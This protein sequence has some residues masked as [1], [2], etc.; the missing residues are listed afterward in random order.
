MFNETINATSNVLTGL[1]VNGSIPLSVTVNTATNW[2]QFWL[3]AG[4]A[5]IT[6]FGLI[7]LIYLPNLV[8]S[9]SIG[10]LSKIFKMTQRNVVLIKHT[11][12]GLFG[13]SMIDQQCLRDLSEVMN[14][15]EGADFDLILHSPGGDIFSSLTLSRLIKQYPGHIR[16]IIP[17]YS[18]SG[19]SLLALSCKELLMT[20]NACIGP[21]DPQLGSLFKFG[22]AKAW[23]EIVKFKGRKAEDQSISFAMMGK[24]YTK[25]ISAHLGQV[26]DFNLNAS[27]KDKLIKFLTDGSI[28]HAYPLT[29][30]DLIKFGIPVYTLSNKKFLKLLSKIISSPGKE[31]VTYYKKR[32][33]L[34]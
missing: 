4:I 25:S 32:K 10:G 33:S 8:R 34:W 31:G 30:N 15:F 21:I 1:L 5:L 22:S 11:E 14:K 13:G 28:E 29:I 16:A 6:S 12:Q 27:Q 2:T 19:G 18:M 24:Q 7:A 23:E 9:I 17:L 26:I 3:T 20:P